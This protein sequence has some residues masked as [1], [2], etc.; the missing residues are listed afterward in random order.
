MQ[1]QQSGLSLPSQP[2]VRGVV[3]WVVVQE[4]LRVWS[5]GEDAS[6][7]QRTLSLYNP[8]L[9]TSFYYQKVLP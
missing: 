4:G 2:P 3:G 6:Y 5:G 8:Y 7:F 9:D 1:R